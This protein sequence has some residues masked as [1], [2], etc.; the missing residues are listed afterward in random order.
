[1]N[2]EAMTFD[3]WSGKIKIATTYTYSDF[4]GLIYSAESLRNTATTKKHI[5]YIV[6]GTPKYYILKISK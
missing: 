5:K 6:D 1:M 3:P 2:F 4:R